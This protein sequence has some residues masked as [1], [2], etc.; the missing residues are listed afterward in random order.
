MNRRRRAPTYARRTILGSFA[1]AV[2]FAACGGGSESP[3]P[4]PSPSRGTA[5]SSPATMPATSLATA[6]TPTPSPTPPR[7]PTAAPTATATPAPGSPLPVG[8]PI[9]AAQR[10]GQ[11][12]GL[13]GS[14]SIAWGEG[15]AALPYSRDDQPS[16]DPIRANR[17]G[18]NARVHVE[19][20]GRP[21]VDWYIPPGTPIRATMDGEA[22]LHVITVSNAFDVYGVSREPY[23][24]D[25]DRSRAPLNAFPGPGGGMGVFVRVEGDGYRT[26]YG[27]MQLLATARAL[28][29]GALLPGFEA[30]DAL[31]T[32]FTPLRDYRTWDAVARWKVRRGDLLGYSGDSGYSEAPHLHYAIAT[33][34][35]TALCPTDE[36]GFSGEKGWLFRNA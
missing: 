26:D 11:V 31:I 8:F 25:P 19:Y 20:E 7:P 30:N 24:G 12:N 9:D 6:T 13:V 28:P 36:P 5:T 3:D 16:T 21:A 18:W 4:S 35:G 14:R 1:G 15:P 32:R 33:S 17:C 2:A 29:A 23:I 22:T 34:D 10:T 27:H